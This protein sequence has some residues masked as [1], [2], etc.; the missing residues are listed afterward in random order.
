LTV[1]QRRKKSIQIEQ[2]NQSAAIG[3]DRTKGGPAILLQPCQSLTVGLNLLQIGDLGGEQA[4][5]A[6]AIMGG[7]RHQDDSAAQMR[8][9][10]SGADQSMQV[11]HGNHLATI[12]ERPGECRRGTGER[13]QRDTRHHFLNA[14]DIQGKTL[15]ANLENEC[16]H[17]DKHG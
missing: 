9:T 14:P 4:E 16:K 10:L 6:P 5:E 3:Q 15:A 13:L 8:Q 12:D 2:A 11:E 17:D 1:N 7:L